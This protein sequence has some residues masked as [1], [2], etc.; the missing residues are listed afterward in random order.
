MQQQKRPIRDMYYIDGS[1][2]RKRES[3][4]AA[5]ARRP[6][7]PRRETDPERRVRPERPV[8]PERKRAIEREKA[9]RRQMQRK[10]AESVAFDFR[11]T[12]FLVI[13]TIIMVASC[14]FLLMMQQRIN[15]Q[16]KEIRVLQNK[17]QTV[18]DDNIA[19]ENALASMYT[20]DDI[21]EIA[22]KQLGMVYAKK[23]QIVYYDSA[24]EDYV[25]QYQDVPE[26]R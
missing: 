26:T 12:A 24:S 5:P 16:K 7:G 19:Y 21:Y 17:I 23:G 25:N 9:H 18:N 15:R 8:S 3:Y 2:V 10:A 11:Y 1:T 13:M 20:I 22:T 6:E 4:E 14:S